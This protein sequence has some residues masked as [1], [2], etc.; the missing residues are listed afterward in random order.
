MSFVV[1]FGWEKPEVKQQL[2]Y[3]GGD[4]L[5]LSFHWKKNIPLLSSI[6]QDRSVETAFK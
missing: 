5:E 6:K 2:Q 3:R 1:I 4:A